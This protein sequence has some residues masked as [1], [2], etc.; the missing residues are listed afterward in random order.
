[1]KNSMIFPLVATL[2]SL[3]LPCAAATTYNIDTA[4]ST[5]GWRGEKITSAHW[6]QV[7]VQGGSVT[8]DDAGQVTGANIT[9][10]MTAMTNTDIT[11]PGGG[12]RLVGHLKSDDF[13]SVDAHPTATF[14]VTGVQPADGTE[15]THTLVGDLTIKGQTHPASFPAKIAVDGKTASA[16]GTL[17]FDRTTWG[18]RYGSGSFMADL[19]DRAILDNVTLTIDIRATAST[20]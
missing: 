19:G 18:I 14:T 4:A 10:D 12:E 16:S 9:I 20:P 11:R 3:A 6:G 5:V 2:I 17:V 15:A 13:F 1:M 7:G 8:V